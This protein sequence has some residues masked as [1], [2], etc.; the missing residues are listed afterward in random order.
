MLQDVW[1]MITWVGLVLKAK[2]W[3]FWM[4]NE[5]TDLTVILTIST[6]VDSELV[7]YG[8]DHLLCLS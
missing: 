1:T 5:V 8:K 7:Q 4:T 3:L 6:A 2:N